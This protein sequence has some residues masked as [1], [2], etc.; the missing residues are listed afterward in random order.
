[1]TNKVKPSKVDVIKVDSKDIEVLGRKENLNSVGKEIAVTM[2]VEAGKAFIPIA[3]EAIK[4]KIELDQ[5]TQKLIRDDKR[6]ILN[7]RAETL[8]LQI[9]NEEGKEDYNQERINRWCKEL[10]D[11]MKKQDVMNAKSESFTKGMLFTA[12]E[13]LSSKLK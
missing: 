8:I 7:K 10:E 4:K 13:F 12:K 5:E 9:E 1:M 3:L 6:K 11:I 2:A